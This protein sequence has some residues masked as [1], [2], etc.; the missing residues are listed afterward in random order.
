[1]IGTVPSYLAVRNVTLEEGSFFSDEQNASAARVAVVGPTARDD[2]FGTTTDGS[3][4]DAV[5]RSIRIK[6]TT[7]KVIGVTVAKGG[8][9][10]QQRRRRHLR[11]A[12]GRP[13]LLGGH[14]D[15]GQLHQRPGLL[16][17]DHEPAAGGHHQPPAGPPQDL[18]TRPAPTS[19]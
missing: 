3:A 7:F 10:L 18:R 8:S 1:M 11:A 5:G 9:G 12:D 17:E 15:H 14:L 4:I 2:L 19:R 13:A 6:G 16:R